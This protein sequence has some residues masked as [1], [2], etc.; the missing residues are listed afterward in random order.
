MK[1]TS[2][3][4]LAEIQKNVIEQKVDVWIFTEVSKKL[5]DKLNFKYSNT[6]SEGCDKGAPKGHYWTAICSDHCLEN[7]SVSDPIRT[8]AV[9]VHPNNEASF[10]V[11]GTVLPWLGSEWRTFASAGGAAFK[12][13]LEMQAGDWKCLRE[14]YPNDEFFVA[15]DFN[16]DL[17]DEQDL[18][19]KPRYYGSVK[20]RTALED[21]L[22]AAKL[23]ALTG[24]GSDPVRNKS[25]RSAC[26]DHICGRVDSRWT[27]ENTIRWPDTEAP[28]RWLSD[29]FGIAVVLKP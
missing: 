16:Q 3:K 21:A 2:D 1:A 17:V 18:V 12:A 6:S 15:G 29:H 10:V 5:I 14:K 28:L 25:N 4:R 7:L 24:G 27:V 19:N 9:R 20:N 26:I 23:C 11:F 13:A 22:G 8:A